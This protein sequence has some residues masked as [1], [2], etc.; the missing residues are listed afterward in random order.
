MNEDV[1]GGDS[2]GE[3]MSGMWDSDGGRR[4]VETVPLY[5]HSRLSGQG[6]GDKFRAKMKFTRSLSTS[7]R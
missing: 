2:V 5:I 4:K 7:N 6:Q 1:E 3:G